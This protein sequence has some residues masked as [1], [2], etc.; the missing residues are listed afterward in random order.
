M[1]DLFQQR[2]EEALGFHKEGKFAD[3]EK[4]YHRLL[5][6]KYDNPMLLYLLGDVFLRTGRNG[7]AINLFWSALVGQPDFQEALID[8]GVALKRE[9]HD[10]RARAAW[11]KA[12]ALGENKEILINLA[13][14][15]ADSGGPDEALGFLNRALAIAP[16]ERDGLWNKALAL[17]AKGEWADGWDLHESRRQLDHWHPRERFKLD[18]WEGEPGKHV[19]VHGEQGLG[20]EVMY[21]S[22]LPDILARSRKVTV[23]CE[24]RLIPL[25]ERS[26]PGVRAYGTQE[27]CPEDDYDFILPMGTLPKLFRR[28]PEAFPGTPYL[29]T[30]PQ[31]VAH[32]QR[33]LAKLGPRP[34]IGLGWFGGV[35]ETRPHVRSVPLAWLLPVMAGRTC[36]SVQYGQ[37]SI[38][39]AEEVGLPILDETLGK[40]LDEQAA[41]V[42]ACDCVVT[43]CQTLAHLSGA[44]GKT[45]FVMTPTRCSWR[46]GYGVEG[47]R[48]SMP[49][50]GSVH[51][52]RQQKAME[53]GPVVNRAAA[54]VERIE[55]QFLG[56]KLVKAA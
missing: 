1:L 56:E 46:Y 48:E 3:A 15:T 41:L 19:L 4:I 8:L 54:E 53:W 38:H 20:D 43:V 32:Y 21:L 27:E 12:L 40:S 18:D 10:E 39:D 55:A 31:R 44:L 11:E 13:T 7:A 35:S 51:L 25:I 28:S 24:P 36:V 45:A 14:L 26:F 22:C 49:W 9:H 33:E 2:M 34:W 17:L 30:D 16:D 52:L 37:L 47:E 5:G 29:K 23:E 50:Y 6:I 42:E